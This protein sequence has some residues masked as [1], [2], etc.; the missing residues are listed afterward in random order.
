M[1]TKWVTLEKEKMEQQNQRQTQDEEV[2]YWNLRKIHVERNRGQTKIQ[3]LQFEKFS[4][5]RAKLSA[6]AR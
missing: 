6:R 3:I 1:V 4:F 2:A 5:T